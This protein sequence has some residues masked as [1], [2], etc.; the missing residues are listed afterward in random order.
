VT[1]PASAYSPV[2]VIGQAVKP[3]PVPYREGVTVLQAVLAVGGLSNFAAGNRA[4]P[5]RMEN[6]K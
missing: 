4:H 3:A 1:Q 5:V 2:K 6:G